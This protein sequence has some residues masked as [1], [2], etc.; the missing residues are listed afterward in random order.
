[1]HVL[2][3]C[4][5]VS[6]LPERTARVGHLYP[7]VD[8]VETFEAAESSPS[9]A[10][11]RAN[12]KL[13]LVRSWRTDEVFAEP[14]PWCM[15]FLQKPCA[16]AWTGSH[17]LPAGSILNG[18]SFTSTYWRPLQA[19][20]LHRLANSSYL[21]GS[22]AE[23]DA[24]VVAGPRVWMRS[25]GGR[26]CR[27]RLEN[28]CPGKPLVYLEEGTDADFSAYKPC[29]N[30]WRRA[31]SC[32]HDRVL[33][34]TGGAAGRL[35]RREVAHCRQLEVPWLAHARGPRTL[36]APR[37]TSPESHGTALVAYSG[38]AKSSWHIVGGKLGFNAWRAQLH[39]ACA[40]MPRLCRMTAPVCKGSATWAGCYQTLEVYAEATFCLQPPGDMLARPGILDALSVGCIPV[41]LHPLQQALWRAFW[42]ASAA[43]VLL[44]WTSFGNSPASYP[45]PPPSAAAAAASLA[46]LRHIS[47]ERVERMRAAGRA[48]LPKLLY[49]RSEAE[50][51]AEPH[52]DAFDAVMRAVAERLRD[53]RGEAGHV[54]E[55]E[56]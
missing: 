25:D 20:L 9:P 53:V 11:V 40:G 37:Q 43:S 13:H 49:A 48:A 29:R 22:E 52:G 4:S 56:G 41:F 27:E 47:T 21:V 39:G 28:V 1:M 12:L 54:L 8:P 32:A 3:A 38:S 46:S 17:A 35:F 5:A 7:S 23:A 30:V 26:R 33:R 50:A 15:D 55:S 19:I 24:C 34:L 6:A 36:L 42:N 14:A 51:R 44:D 31:P 45:L 16:E 10:P 18:S 2:L